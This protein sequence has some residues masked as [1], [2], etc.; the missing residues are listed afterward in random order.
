[1]AL[2][3][4][5]DKVKIKLRESI[6]EMVCSYESSGLAAHKMREGTFRIKGITK[7]GMAVP[8]RKR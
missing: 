6:E 5:E 7:R 1:M 8:R 3:R 4:C 2:A